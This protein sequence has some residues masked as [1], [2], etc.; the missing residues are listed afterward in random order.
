MPSSNSATRLRTPSLLHQPRWLTPCALSLLVVLVACQAHNAA[1]PHLVED[2]GVTHP[3]HEKLVGKIVFTEGLIPLDA[4]Q[5]SSFRSSFFISEDS[6]LAF[7]AFLERSLVNELHTLDRTLSAEDLSANGNYQFKFF[8]DGDLVFTEN[9]NPR[10]GSFN[11]KSRSTI[12]RAP[13]VSTEGEDYWPRFMWARFFHRDGGEALLKNGPH[14]FRIEMR[15]YLRQEESREGDLLAAGEIR[16]TLPAPPPVTE[17]QVAVQEI[18]PDSGWPLSKARFDE[19]KIRELNRGIFQNDFKQI[20]GLVV[21]QDGELLLEQY[22]NGADRSTLHDPR[23]VGKT[24]ASAVTGIALADQHL[25]S[26]EQTLSEFYDL[27]RFENHS[28]AKENVTL[29]SLLTMSSG[30]DATDFDSESPGNEENMYPTDDWVRFA[31][32]LSMDETKELGKNWDYFT[33]GVVV[34]GDILHKSVPGG[35][36]DYAEKKLFA[37]LGIERYQWPY[38]PQGVANTAGGLA[39]RALDFAKFGQVYKN[40]GTWNGKQVLPASWVEASL[41][42]YFPNSDQHD[43]YGYLFWRETFTV[44][45][46]AVEAYLCSGNGG[47]KIY[48]FPDHPL[49]IV[50]TASAYG[51]M[52]GHPQVARLM[53][54]YV[55]PAILSDR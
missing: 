31:L 17:E 51:R 25:E 38:T 14:D 8:V 12:L 50:V 42:N 40:G 39:M 6:N 27:S 44:N 24:F 9:L 34:L 47:N 7:T 45:G 20:N 23:S 52:Y 53:T 2:D 49:V 54:N 26:T 15:S 16:L 4:Y 5:E 28:E 33:A 18:A 22:F 21:I 37:P 46:E 10:A 32:D 35:L 41:S 19:Q 43:G 1:L 36:E 48:I 11:N 55:L 3:L 29:K 30:F 13:L